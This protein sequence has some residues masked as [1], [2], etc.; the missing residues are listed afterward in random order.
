MRKQLLTLTLLAT[1]TGCS[2][3]PGVYKM[4]VPQGNPV[5][6]EQLNQLRPGMTQSQVRYVM[7]TPLVEDT[8]HENR[9]DYI[10]HLVEEDE[11]TENNRVQLYFE[12]GRLVRIGGDMRPGAEPEPQPEQPEEATAQ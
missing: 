11:M 9:W 6:Q 4:P 1:L 5:T 2:D 12:N 3:F 10:Y 8:F 7:G